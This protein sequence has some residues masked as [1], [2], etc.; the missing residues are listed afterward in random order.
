MEDEVTGNYQFLHDLECGNKLVPSGFIYQPQYVWN[1][2][3]QQEII[4]P[5]KCVMSLFNAHGALLREKQ[6]VCD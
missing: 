4:Q 3:Y 2:E 6:C 1:I 5:I